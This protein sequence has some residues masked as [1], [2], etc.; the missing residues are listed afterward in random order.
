M[1]Y[2]SDFNLLTSALLPHDFSFFN[3]KIQIA[4]LDHAIWFHRNFNLN[5]WMLYSIDSPNAGGGRGFCT[6]HIFSQEG[7]LVA[8]VTQEGLIR[9]KGEKKVKS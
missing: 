2:F 9:L 3:Q 6:G 1:T 7:K 5:D 4:S 8:S